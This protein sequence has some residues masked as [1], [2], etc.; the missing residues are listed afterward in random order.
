[1]DSDTATQTI[2]FDVDGMT[3]ATCATRVERVLSRQEGVEGASVNL[4]SASA[5]VRTRA[6]S[7]AAALEAAVGKIGYTLRRHEAGEAPRDM[8]EHYSDDERTQWRRFWFSAALSLPLMLL[9]MFGPEESWNR[10]IQLVLATPVVAVAGWQYHRVAGRLARHLSANMDTLISLGSIAAY[11]YSIW[12][13][14]VDEPVFFETAGVIITLITLGRAFEARAK[15]RASTTIHRLLGLSAKEARIMGPN[16]EKMVP[17]DQVIPGDVM[18]VHP[19]EKIPTDGVVTKGSTAIDESM[20][21]G[22]SVPVEKTTG[23]QVFGAT[24]NFQSRIEVEAT[25]VGSDTALAGI[26]RLVEEAQ[27]SK[28]PIQRLADRIS[29]IFVPVVIVISIATIT[30]WMLLGNPLEESFSAGVAVL[31]I[32]CPCAL[33]LATPTAIMAGTG[34]GAELGILFKRAEVFE[35]ATSVD[36]ALFDKTGTITTGSMEL[37]DFE[38]F[39]GD[40]VFQI[41][42]S[43]E[44]ASGHPIGKAVALAADEREVELLETEDVTAVTGLG[45]RGSIGGRTVYI[46]KSSLLEDNGISVNETHLETLGRWETK[47]WTAFLAGWDG[48][49]K[50]LFAVADTVRPRARE[51][52]DRLRQAGVLT[53]M[54]T[55][56]NRQTAEAIAAQVGIDRVIAEVMPGQKSDEVKRLQDDGLSVAFV[57]DGINDAPALVQ[58]DIGMA[59]G[60][61]TEVAVDAGDVVL[62]NDSPLLVPTPIDLATATFKTIKQNLFWAF[63]YNTAAIPLAAAGLLNPMIAAGAMAF[64]SVSVVLNALRLRRFRGAIS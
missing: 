13:L 27:G 48:Q 63:A 29:G 19:G 39:G 45:V 14:F 23:D 58:A 18:V 16:G 2:Q 15:G 4:A 1:M 3:C 34:K 55:G 24:V 5:Q 46:G 22:E 10:L 41:V 52:M 59:I 9:A 17:I 31:I 25:A 47:S 40:E 64:S 21:T 8:V 36:A 12:A 62:L 26:V 42:A 44:N 54:I 51:T 56:D 32:A 57:G 20:L 60:S 50:A 61:G 28:A 6:G 37:V 43:I 49:V 30:T 7:D 53:A 35:Q 11:L 33:G 38:S